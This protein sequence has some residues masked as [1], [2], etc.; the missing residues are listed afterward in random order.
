MIP[1]PITFDYLYI[2]IYVNYIWGTYGKP[3]LNPTL[4]T[5]SIDFSINELCTRGQFKDV[6]ITMDPEYRTKLK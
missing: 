2:Y 6:N 3:Y 5:Y 4:I 1:K